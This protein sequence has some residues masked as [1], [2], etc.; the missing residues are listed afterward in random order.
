MSKVYLNTLSNYLISRGH[1]EEAGYIKALHKEAFEWPWDAWNKLPEKPKQEVVDFLDKISFIPVI[2]VGGDSAKFILSLYSGKYSEA[3]R[4][5][6]M[7][8]ISF[9]L[10]YKMV[11]KIL[12]LQK[13]SGS[14]I[15]DF[16]NITLKTDRAL[17]GEII[18]FGVNLID[19]QFDKI[20]SLLGN[21][22]TEMV[23]S[24]AREFNNIRGSLDIKREIDNWLINLTPQT[25]ISKI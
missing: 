12:T 5:L 19:N 23:V 15:K 3:A 4:S 18:G 22:K 7:V 24:L 25:F 9:V 11:G 14:L 10:Q 2:G 6:A 1:L 20:S 8:V 16:F 13:A 21:Y 17:Q